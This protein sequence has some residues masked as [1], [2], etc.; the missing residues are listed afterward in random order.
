MAS[1]FTVY[2]T[3]RFNRLAEDLAKHHQEFARAYERCIEI[4]E[5]DPTNRNH[6]RDIKKLEDVAAGDG[7]YRLRFFYPGFPIWIRPAGPKGAK[8]L[9]R[10]RNPS[11]TRR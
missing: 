4:L 3:P 2:I 1:N 5:L 8:T 6:D 10:P 7:Q 11:F 9:T